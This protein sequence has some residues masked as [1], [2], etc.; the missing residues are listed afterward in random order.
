MVSSSFP[1]MVILSVVN[2]VCNTFFLAVA[3]GENENKEC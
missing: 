2:L 3:I 1:S